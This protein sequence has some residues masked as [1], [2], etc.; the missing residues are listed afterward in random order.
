M[1][2]WGGR[3]SEANRTFG[4]PEV[5]NTTVNFLMRQDD[6]WQGGRYEPMPP[7]PE[8][9]EGVDLYIQWYSGTHWPDGGPKWVGQWYFE[10]Y[11]YHN[12]DTPGYVP[13][14]PPPC[15]ER[16]KWPYTD[17]VSAA[18]PNN[19]VTVRRSRP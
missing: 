15:P 1:Q 7:Y 10:L 9:M 2:Y 13:E 16:P 6:A 11:S 14:V 17:P 18:T 4:D 12:T 5:G 8:D 19:G 3:G